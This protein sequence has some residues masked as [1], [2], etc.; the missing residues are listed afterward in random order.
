MQFRV[1]IEQ[2]QPRLDLALIDEVSWRG[3]A[4]I[5]RGGSSGRVIF[6]EHGEEPL[7]VDHGRSASTDG[8]GDLPVAGDHGESARGGGSLDEASD[9]IVRG[10]AGPREP[11]V[12]RLVGDPVPSRRSVTHQDGGFVTEPASRD[13]IRQFVEIDPRQ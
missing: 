2:S 13:E 7:G 12:H 10:P 8:L 6:R 4:S 3:V 1:E 5:Q 9:E 11:D